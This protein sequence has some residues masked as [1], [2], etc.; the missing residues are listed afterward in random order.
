[1]NELLFIVTLIFLIWVIGA[2]VLAFSFYKL[3][4]SMHGALDEQYKQIEKMCRRTNE[5]EIELDTLQMKLE[6]LERTLG[7]MR[8]FDYK[9][10]S[11]R[12]ASPGSADY[13]RT[14]H[15]LREGTPSAVDVAMSAVI[16]NSVEED[17]SGSKTSSYSSDDNSSNYSS[18]SSSYSD[19]SSSSSFD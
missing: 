10:T 12:R 7:S 16:L 6:A 4:S 2:S 18:S 17:S 9:L 11:S 14:T 19:S 3:I 1:M 15:R 13:S 5:Q 8:S